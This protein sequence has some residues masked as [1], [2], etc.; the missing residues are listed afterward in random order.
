MNGLIWTGF[1]V[2]ILAALSYIPIFVRFPITRDFPWANLLLF[3]AGGS[4]IAAGLY[5][6][7][8]QP[9]RYRGKISGVVAGGLAVT[10]FVLFYWGMFV[11]A[12]QI[13]AAAEAPR[14]GSQAPDF[15]LTDAG[16]KSVSLAEMRKANRYVLLIFYR[17]YW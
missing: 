16:G 9:E 13:P 4:M 11:F 12:R 14:A 17:G 6:A 10:L 8:G 5:R 1:A 15:T 3:A 2:V 7:Y